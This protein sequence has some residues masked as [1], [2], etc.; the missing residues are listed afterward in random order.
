MGH[1][2]CNGERGSALGRHRCI[3]E[4]NLKID[5]GEIGCEVVNWV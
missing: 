4:D 3:W 1:V 5:L 2:A